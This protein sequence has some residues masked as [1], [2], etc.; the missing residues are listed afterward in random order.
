MHS[1]P[2]FPFLPQKR[3]PLRSLNFCWPTLRSTGLLDI[4][5]GNESYT[6]DPDVVDEEFNMWRP[7]LDND[8]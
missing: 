3:R 6:E 2:P 4:V 5:L 1:N 7:D 8:E